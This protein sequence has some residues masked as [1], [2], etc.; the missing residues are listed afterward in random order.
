[1]H[2]TE[3]HTVEA[4]LEELGRRIERHRLERN[5]TQQELAE[6]AGVGRATV[7]RLE[8]GDDVQTSSWIKLLDALDLLDDVD[9]ALPERVASPVAE[10]ERQQRV[11]RRAR[12]AKPPADRDAPWTWGDE[13]DGPA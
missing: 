12:A 8:R 5:W 7:Q 10:L 3:L 2:L 6:R 13:R 11:R 1:M 4:R 9:A